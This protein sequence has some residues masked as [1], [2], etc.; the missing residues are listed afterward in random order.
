M[1]LATLVVGT[2][3]TSTSWGM[4][5]TRALSLALLLSCALASLGGVAVN[6]R[7][8]APGNPFPCCEDAGEGSCNEWPTNVVNVTASLAT[9]AQCTGLNAPHECCTTGSPTFTGT[10]DGL[11]GADVKEG[12]RICELGT[13]KIVGQ[14]GGLDT[15]DTFGCILQLPCNATIENAENDI[16]SANVSTTDDRHAFAYGSF[17]NGLI[18]K[19][20]GDN[21]VLRSKIPPALNSVL[22]S[23]AVFYVRQWDRDLGTAGAQLAVPRIAFRDFQCDG[24]TP[25]QKSYEH[26]TSPWRDETGTA[27]NTATA[28]FHG[29][30]G[31]RG[32]PTESQFYEFFEISGVHAHHFAGQILAV[33]GVGNG[34]MTRN[35]VHDAGCWNDFN[36]GQCLANAAPNINNSCIGPGNP[37]AS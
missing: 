17:R 37:D 15:K 20:C 5:L 12:L 18:I 13:D 1:L 8:I 31:T 7:C 6:K 19:G 25:L 35:Y 27:V 34:L 26:E 9:N 21:T 30:I 14:T 3:S 29:C 28:Q 33:G 10:C 11:E 36:T 32:F 24:Q 2:A 23:G 4:A 16:Y 22:P